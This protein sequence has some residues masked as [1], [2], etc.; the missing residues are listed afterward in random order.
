MS[1][2]KLAD[3]LGLSQTTVSRALNGYPEVS[4]ATRARVQEEARRMNY[5]PDARARSLATGRSMAVGYVIPEATQHELVNPIF[6]DFIAG[7]GRVYSESGYD[8]MLTLVADGDES[9]A[10]RRL[11]ARG[12]VDGIVVQVPRPND[13]RI[14]ML[15]DIKMPFIV[16]GR[17]HQDD[18]DYS[19]LDM[20]NEAAFA[21]ATRHLTDL[22]H[23]K[24][25]L[26]N[27]PEEAHFAI[28]RKTGFAE[29]L[30]GVGGSVRPEWVVSDQMTEQF[31]YEAGCRL[32][33]G[34]E[35]PTAVL[36]ASMLIATG[37]R[38]AIEEHGFVMGRDISVVAHDDDLSYLPNGSPGAPVFTATRVSVRDAG[39]MAAEMLLR[40]INSPEMGPLHRLQETELVLG[41]SSGPVPKTT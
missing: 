3:K 26:L 12:R 5:A 34:P 13:P 1:L 7:A 25:A 32:L 39:R 27:G 37:L 10:Y 24:I 38:R 14:G 31:G 20:D 16:H 33:Q 23:R 4:A 6:A 35:R 8:M 21:L 22:G 17:A 9:A 30:V 19:W 40:L 36:A 2:R 18:V 15:Q 28:M 11:G 29:T 41:P